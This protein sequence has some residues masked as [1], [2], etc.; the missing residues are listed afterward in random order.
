MKSLKFYLS[1][2]FAILS[3]SAKAQTFSI[4]GKITSEIKKE[5]LSEITVSLK[6]SEYSTVTDKNGRYSLSNIKPGEYI[7][8]V[9]SLEHKRIEKKIFVTNSD[10]TVDVSLNEKITESDS[11]VVVGKREK[12][13]GISRL[14]DVD[15]TAIYAGKKS[16]VI[17]MEDITAN[18]ATN[19]SRQIYSKIAGLNIWENDGAGIQLGIGGRGLNPNRVSNFNTRQNGYDMSADALGYPESY[20]SPPAEAIERIEIVRGAASL[21]Y[22]TQFGGLVNFKLKKGPVDKKIQLTS[23]QTIGSWRFSNTFNSLGGTIK[24]V[25]YYCF[26]QRKSGDGWRPNSEFNVNTAYSSIVYNLNSKISVT[27][28]YTFMDYLA[29]QPGGLTDLMFEKDPRQSIRTRNWFKVNWNLGAVLFDYKINSR[30]KFNSRFFGLMASRSAL[31]VLTYINRAD[32]MTDRDLWV[33]NYRNLG[34]ESRL[35]YR[36]TIGRAPVTTVLGFRYYS[37]HTERK[38]GLGNDGTEGHKSDFIFDNPNDLEYS[39]YTFPNHNISVFTENIIQLNSKLSIIPGIR[40]EN[41]QTVADGFYNIVNKDLAGNIIFSEKTVEHRKNN[42]S[43]ILGGVGL[44]Y[45]RND[46]FQFYANISQNYRAINFNDMHVVNPNLRVD[47][48]LQD[49]KGYSADMGCRGTISGILNYDLSLFMISYKNRIGT[50]IKTDTTTFNLYRL[51]T[52]ISDSRNIGLESFIELDFWRLIKGSEAKSKISVFSNFTLID[53]RYIHSRQSA[54]ENKKVELAP[55]TIFKTGLSYKTNRF[56]VSYQFSHTSS[57]FTDASNA[58]YT[59]TA[60]NGIIPAY[61][62]M[63]VSAEFK[64][65]KIFMLS[66]SINNLS[67]NLYYTRRADSYPG[68]GIIPSDGRSFFVTLQVKL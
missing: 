28:Q 35:L 51:R 20:Y 32:P 52:N 22:G 66:G 41:I 6:N 29:H 7:L 44:S 64:I 18:T 54:F 46:A 42:R 21:Q 59:S 33:D 49:E 68:P 57:Q 67:N 23:R 47:P 5:V 4:R 9:Q 58:I 12:T 40:F 2:I 34:N 8:V 56:S 62:T 65:S 1:I 14:K 13:F 16:E 50:V 30:L 63:D 17:V 26:Y 48:N 24:K 38:Q 31:G 53:A 27:V 45:S 36:D 43:F 55:N 19:N 39:K 11:V 25:N 10:L 3:F 60:I 37:G 15:G 61:Y